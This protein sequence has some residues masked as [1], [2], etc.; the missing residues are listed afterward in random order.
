[1][2]KLLLLLSLA[3]ALAQAQIRPVCAPYVIVTPASNYVWSTPKFG[4]TGNGLYFKYTCW[5]TRAGLRDHTYTYVGLP[6]ELSKIG[7]RV[8]TMVKAADPLLS[9]QSFPDRVQM[10]PISDLRLQ[11]IL[12]DA[13]AGK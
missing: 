8:S 2:K 12:Q 3:P 4:M 11:P 10:L 1:M 9:L 13:E 5:A 6:S 7:G